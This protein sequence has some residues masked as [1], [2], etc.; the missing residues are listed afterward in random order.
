MKVVQR[1]PVRIAL[2]P[3]EL[4]DHPLR[5]GLS[6]EVSVDVA[7]TDGKT[8]A[9]ATRTSAPYTTAAFNHDTDDADALVRKTIAANLG[10]PM[11]SSSTANTAVAKS[12]LPSLHPD[13]PAISAKA[14]SGRQL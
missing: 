6:M 7:N 1:L 11:Q 3:K 14:P 2:D 8:L 4:A 5:V 12:N 9:A 10:R 13:A